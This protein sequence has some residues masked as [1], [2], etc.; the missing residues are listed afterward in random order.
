VVG[1]RGWFGAADEKAGRG[2]RTL[3]F[4][5]EGY[6]STIELHPQLAFRLIRWIDHREGLFRR[7]ADSEHADWH[8]G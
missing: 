4:S 6:C 1:F 5:L 8:G 2:N 7:P 3:V